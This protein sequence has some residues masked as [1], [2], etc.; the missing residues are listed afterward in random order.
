[1][2]RL[3]YARIGSCRE[4]RTEINALAIT[5]VN[6]RISSDIELAVILDK[7]V[8]SSGTYYD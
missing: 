7:K 5:A 1:M 6:L 2:D 4:L 3:D 8:E